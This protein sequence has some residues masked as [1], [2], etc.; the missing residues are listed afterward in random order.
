[1]K[2]TGQKVRKIASK[3]QPEFGSNPNVGAFIPKPFGCL[4]LNLAIPDKAGHPSKS[5][6]M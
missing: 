5:N 3:G 2:R 4:Q 1:M 6:P